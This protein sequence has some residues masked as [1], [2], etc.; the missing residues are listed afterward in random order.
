[1]L[2]LNNEVVKFLSDSIS[3]RLMS[4][5][6]SIHG[7]MGHT[8]GDLSEQ[9]FLQA[10]DFVFIFGQHGSN[11]SDI[12]NIFKPESLINRFIDTISENIRYLKVSM[13]Y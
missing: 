5:K 11:K 3:Y 2:T 9:E 1:M 8:S 10:N 13:F 4:F 7:A 12:L 6:D